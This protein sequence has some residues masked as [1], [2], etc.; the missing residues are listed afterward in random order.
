MIDNAVKMMVIA[1]KEQGDSE[2]FERWQERT[3]KYKEWINAHQVK[4]VKAG[5]KLDVCDTEHI[6][7]KATIELVIKTQ[8]RK[9]LL[10]VHYEGWNRKYD[11]YM[12][13]DSHRISPLGFYTNRTDIPVYRMMNNNQGGGGPV[14]MMYAVVLQNA[15]EGQR[16]EDYERR[17]AANNAQQEEEENDNEEE[18]ESQGDQMEVVEVANVQDD[19]AEPLEEDQDLGDHQISIPEPV[20]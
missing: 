1:K 8:N 6:W 4:S 9:D 19:P 2:D 15:A 16:L 12:Y 7:C 10:Y 5:Q 17:M 13:I 18:H 11:E 14:Q 20:P 3:H